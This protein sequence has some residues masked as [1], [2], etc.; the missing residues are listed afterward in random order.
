MYVTLQLRN[1]LMIDVIPHGAWSVLLEIVCWCDCPNTFLVSFCNFEMM[2]CAEKVVANSELDGPEPHI[3][4]SSG[5]L[6]E[7]R[8]V[9][10]EELVRTHGI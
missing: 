6:Q 4:L 7:E 2:P 1:C 8:G 3:A 10:W 9:F 5:S